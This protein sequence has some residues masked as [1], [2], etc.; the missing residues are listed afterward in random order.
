MKLLLVAKQ[1]ITT[2]KASCTFGAFEWLLLG[3]GTLVPFQVLE[4]CEG[5]LASCANMR[6]GLVCLGWGEVGRWRLGVYGDCRSYTEC[7]LV[8]T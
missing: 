4:T 2:G 7:I 8:S 1:Q 6:A 3:V 5:T